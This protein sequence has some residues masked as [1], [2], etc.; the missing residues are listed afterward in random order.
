MTFY[1]TRSLEHTIAVG[2]GKVWTQ[3]FKQRFCT[4]STCSAVVELS[5]S[6]QW[7]LMASAERESITGVWGQSLN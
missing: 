4:H 7:G 1:C 5:E 2:V 6:F 3:R